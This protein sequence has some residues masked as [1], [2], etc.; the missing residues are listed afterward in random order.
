A[1][2]PAHARTARYRGGPRALPQTQAD[3][4]AGVR[5]YQV[6]PGHRAIQTTRVSGL[7]G[8]VA[9]DHRDAQP[10]QALAEQRGGRSRLIGDDALRFVTA[11][12]A[13]RATSDF[14]K[15]P[16]SQGEASPAP[17]TLIESSGPSWEQ[18]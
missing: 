16:R 13:R 5:P 2:L 10:A 7:P 9:P 3:G 1:S 12:A 6:Q 11:G 4:R 17:S 18:Q 8:R 15:Q 14:T